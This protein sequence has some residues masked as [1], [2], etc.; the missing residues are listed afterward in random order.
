MK[1]GP[2]PPTDH[3]REIIITSRKHRTPVN[4]V[5]LV[6]E[7][8]NKQSDSNLEE[9][10]KDRR[11]PDR[12]RHRSVDF[13]NRQERFLWDLYRAHLLHPFLTFFLFLEKL[14]LP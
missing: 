2:E 6:T 14:A 10:K 3:R 4:I 8:R 12:S 11:D 13:Q 5:G 9:P 7:N 1:Q